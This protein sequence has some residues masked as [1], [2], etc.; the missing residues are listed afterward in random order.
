M[1]IALLNS[2]ADCESRSSLL[3]CL[4]VEG[5]QRVSPVFLAALVYTGVCIMLGW[6]RG[7]RMCHD[8]NIT[9]SHCSLLSLV[10]HA[11]E[12]FF[13]CYILLGQFL[14]DFK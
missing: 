13:I 9:D 2:T 6:L 11:C 7:E 12:C 5:G 4:I 3:E 8:S 14:I 10:A 1:C